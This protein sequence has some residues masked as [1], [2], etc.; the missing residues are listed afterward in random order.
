MNSIYLSIILFPTLLNFISYFIFLNKKESLGKQ[1]ITASSIL[2]LVATIT[3]ST[4]TFSGQS[5]I[6]IA[7][8][9]GIGFSLKIDAL[10]TV[11][12]AMVSLIAYFVLR[13]SF[14]YLDGDPK[15]YKFLSRIVAIT[16]T[17]QVLVLSGNLFMFFLAWVVTSLEL[18]G[19][20]KLYKERKKAFRASRIKFIIARTSDISLLLA[21][22]LLY[23]EFG[24]A[25]IVS[26]TNGLR[27]LGFNNS[28][29]D[30]AA[31]FLTLAAILKSVQFPF[32][33]WILGVLELPTPASALLH[34]GLLNAGPFLI[35]RFALL[36][37]DVP[38]GSIILI[39]FGT[40]SALYGT[41][42]QVTQPSV[43][44][45]LVYSSIGHMGF[46]LL[47]CGLG[48]Y[49]AALV[50][51]VSHSFYKAYSFLTAGSVIEQ[52]RQFN[53]KAFNRKGNAVLLSLT[54]VLGIL[55]LLGLNT[56]ARNYF[57]INENVLFVG[58]I[59]L[60]GVFALN[61]QV[62]DS[63]S[64][65]KVVIRALALSFIVLLSFVVLEEITSEML[66]GAIPEKIG[67]SEWIMVGLVFLFY[68]AS[69]LQ[70]ALA[71]PKVKHKLAAMQVHARNG[72]YLDSI[73]NRLASL[74]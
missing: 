28:K 1:L 41:L 58:N 27:E 70:I 5:L 30:L 49:A 72:F 40:I 47:L 32:H 36:F 12:Y 71:V 6:E 61:L 22:V 24:T 44:T 23:I 43:K 10:T 19:L 31:L 35:I 3:I 74:F 42:V 73:V 7:Q 63:N 66:D 26:I 34:A 56:L 55:L 57:S 21:F 38:T 11:I 15:K 9:A 46:S 48:L 8:N 50:H 2:S 62:M 14:N 33:T 25:D 37:S 69:W 65:V 60:I 16:A 68:I 54:F 29:V 59:V 13:F 64:G 20:L 39:F 45:A 52:A 4:L 51:L 53:L 67:I 17:V 18:Q